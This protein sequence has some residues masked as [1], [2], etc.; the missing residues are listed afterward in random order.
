MDPLAIA[1]KAARKYGLRIYPW[2]TIFDEYGG[3]E[4]ES[5]F[6]KK[7][8]EYLLT[9]RSGRKHFKGVLCYAYPEVRHHRLTEI[10]E[11]M[12][13]GVDGIY[14]C[15]RSHSRFPGLLDKFGFNRP[16]V[17]KYEKLYGRNI[18]RDRYDKEEW[19][20]LLGEGL[21]EFLRETKREINKRDRRL[22]IGIK[23][24]RRIGWPLGNMYLDYEKWMKQRLVDELC[25]GALDWITTEGNIED[26]IAALGLKSLDEVWQRKHFWDEL[27]VRTYR[28]VIADPAKL[29]FWLQLWGW[30]ADYAP[31]GGGAKTKSPQA[32]KNILKSLRNTG[33]DGVA[34]FEAACIDRDPKMWK[35]ISSFVR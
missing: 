22:G 29:Y 4:F 34:L 1:V 27:L 31:R 19:Y 23:N 17:E 32:V 26:Q 8:P 11:L 21:T 28:P 12:E 15:T 20:R 10:R 6:S 2:V 5:G 16:I 33:I 18:L 35:A 25:I 9:D 14:L 7:H 3:P 30:G 24:G 13:Y